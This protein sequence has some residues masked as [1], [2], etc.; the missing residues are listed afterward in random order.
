MD[1]KVKVPGAEVEMK[2]PA[3]EKLVD[4]TASG[5][6][7][8]AGPMLATWIARREAQAKQIAAKGDVEE[9]KILAEGHADKMRTIAKAQADARATLVSPDS[10]VQGE[11]D[12]AQT[13]TQ[14]IQFQEEKRQKNIGT[15]VGH[16]ALELGD[17]DVANSEPDHDWTARFFSDVQD[18]SSEEMQSLWGKVL[19]GEV[20]R[21][22][23]TSILTLSIL[24]NLDQATASIFRKLCS[25]CVS[26]RLDGN[27]FIDARVSSFDGNP[28]N[29][30]LK[31]YGLNFDALNVLNEHGLIISDYNS[32]F[33]YKICIGISSSSPEPTML[34][35]P[36]SF[37]GRY[38][39][40]VSTTERA[41]NQEF[42]LSGVAL[43]RSGREL[44]RIVDL[45]PMNT[46]AQALMKFFETKNLK[47]TEVDNWQPHS[48]KIDTR[49]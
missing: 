23:S 18:V 10:T 41:E 45:E 42:R 27:Q 19:A 25:T 12:I 35:C 37:Q 47:M 44:S 9:Q 6:G 7:S 21:P 30:V 46:Y 34:R 32:W 49:R 11:L 33:D 36:F 29:N 13:V 3:I 17:K 26:I 38:W 20:E 28:G 5:I 2:V 16:A 15:V 39:V 4:Y 48:F 1:M 31:D 22:G 24:R 43:T 8:I 40:L 14:R